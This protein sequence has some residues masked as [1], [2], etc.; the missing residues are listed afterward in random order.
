MEHCDGTDVYQ[1]TLEAFIKDHWVQGYRESTEP[2]VMGEKI[3]YCT[4]IEF[5]VGVEAKVFLS[6]C[7]ESEEGS[8]EQAAMRAVHF[9]QHQRA[10]RG[11]GSGG[12]GGGGGGGSPL[13][14]NQQGYKMEE[15]S[16]VAGE[17][18]TLS[19]PEFMV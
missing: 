15:A 5:T 4:K 8:K 13:A 2:C 11:G 6:D 9:I 12:G 18:T 17:V 10:E 19:K 16:C 7:L 3:V 1:Q 14:T